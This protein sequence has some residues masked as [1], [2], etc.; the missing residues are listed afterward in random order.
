MMMCI[1][2]EICLHTEE[3]L[4]ELVITWSIEITDNSSYS[5]SSHDAY[6]ALFIIVI[7]FAMGGHAKMRLVPLRQP[8]TLFCC[9]H[10]VLH[11]FCCIVENKPSLY[12]TS[13]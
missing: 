4:S 12:S 1:S 2:Y 6:T 9:C 5:L 7:F 3:C 8:S 10:L 13:M 11:I